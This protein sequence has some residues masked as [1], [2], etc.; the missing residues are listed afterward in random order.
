MGSPLSSIIAD[1]VMQDL[2]EIAISNL[3]VHPHILLQIYQ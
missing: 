3:Q 2:E 1:L